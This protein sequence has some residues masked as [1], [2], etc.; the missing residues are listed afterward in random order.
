MRM[1]PEDERNLTE[2]VFGSMLG[3]TSTRAV[4]R[5]GLPCATPSDTET[6]GG[7]TSGI[8]STFTASV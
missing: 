8:D 7:A 3:F 2:L 1:P 6:C 5:T 4:Y